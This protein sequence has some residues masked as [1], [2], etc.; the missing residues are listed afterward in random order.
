MTLEAHRGGLIL[1]LGILGWIPFLCFLAL[2]AM[3]MGS[4][5]LDMMRKG[6]MDRSGEEQTRL[7]FL[8]G[9]MASILLLLLC[10]FGGFLFV[11]GR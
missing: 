6:Y 8:L 10:G 9:T 3:S 11:V 5:D 1:T 7:G 4:H 2:F